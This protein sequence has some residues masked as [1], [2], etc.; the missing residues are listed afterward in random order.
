ML[1]L[2]N[3]IKL[4][5]FGDSKRVSSAENDLKGNDLYQVALR[6]LCMVAGIDS[7]EKASLDFY[8]KTVLFKE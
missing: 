3:Q 4:I 2:K 1:D 8:K 5:D 7:T 6:M